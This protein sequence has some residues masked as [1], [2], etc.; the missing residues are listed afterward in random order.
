MPI[1]VSDVCLDLISRF[2]GFRPTWYRDS[3]GV[4]TIGHGFTEDVDEVDRETTDELTRMESR[5]ILARQIGC[6][7]GPDVQAAVEVE[8]ADHQWWSL[9]CFTYNVGA[10][11]LRRSTLLELLNAR[12]EE[13]AENEFTEWVYAGGRVV[14][15]L[16]RRREAERA[17]FE[18][19]EGPDHDLILDLVEHGG[20]SGPGI[21]SIAGPAD[22]QFVPVAGVE[23]IPDDVDVEVPETLPV[24]PPSR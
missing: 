22:A 12:Q 15:G 7:Y 21:A 24:S 19:D 2:E 5:R 14:D 3:A 16:V 13:E 18:L 23:R 20:R 17:L 4:W 1:P 11:A 9:Y 10:S 8:L 6:R